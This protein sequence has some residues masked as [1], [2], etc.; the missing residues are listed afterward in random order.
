MAP[1]ICPVAF[2]IHTL[3]FGSAGVWIDANSHDDNTTTTTTTTNQTHPPG[4]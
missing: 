3:P 2:L 1:P 4:Q